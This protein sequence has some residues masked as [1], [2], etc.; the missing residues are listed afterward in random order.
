MSLQTLPRSHVSIPALPPSGCLSGT[1][2]RLS[3][4]A[5]PL[6]HTPKQC[7]LAMPPHPASAPCL[8]TPPP[9]HTSRPY[10][11]SIFPGPP[12]YASTPYLH[13][14]SPCHASRQWIALEW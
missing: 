4:Q 1:S 9:F 11:H 5:S 6:A 3:L 10:L 7:L 8:H 2:V 12:S 14:M 13:G